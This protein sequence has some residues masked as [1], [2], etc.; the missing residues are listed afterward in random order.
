MM[1]AVLRIRGKVGLSKDIED[2]LKMLNL[3]RKFNC[4]L[5]PETDD[6]RGMLKKVQN[7]ITW[8]SINKDTAKKIL[9][10]EGI[11]DAS[12]I[13]EGLEEGKTL[14]KMDVKRTF[15][16]S[17]PSGGFKKTTKKIYPKGEAGNRGENADVFF[18]KVV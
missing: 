1:Y 5:V 18:K 7:Y 13:I 11:E 3:K 16:M 8:G 4:T 14:G 2:T 17:P 15:S 9:S 6:Y 12:K 10:K